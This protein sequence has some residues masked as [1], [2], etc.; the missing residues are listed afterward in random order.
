MWENHK[1][2]SI[3]NIT[4]NGS[5]LGS[6]LRMPFC[7]V[8]SLIPQA[9][10]W[11]L[12]KYVPKLLWLEMI[13]YVLS[14]SAAVKPHSW[15]V[16]MIFSA[17]H[18]CI[19]IKGNVLLKHVTNETMAGI[20]LNATC[21]SVLVKHALWG[22][23]DHACLVHTEVHIRAVHLRKQSQGLML[24]TFNTVLHVIVTP[25]SIKLFVFPTS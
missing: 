14:G 7:I 20:K 17:V 24:R 5:T 22:H 15:G 12:Y 4:Q 11:G 21:S 18:Y 10:E 9:R 2:K 3:I 16:K 23:S 13:I 25:P 6:V 19:S 1:F 8:F